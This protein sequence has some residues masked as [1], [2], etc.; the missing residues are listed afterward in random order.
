MHFFTIL[1][2]FKSKFV[3]LRLISELV[4]L[5]HGF[6][7]LLLKNVLEN[8]NR[9]TMN[10]K[11]TSKPG[12]KR[13]GWIVLHIKCLSVYF[14]SLSRVF[15]LASSQIFHLMMLCFMNSSSIASKTLA[16]S[17][18][19]MLIV[20]EWKHWQ[21][22][23]NPQTW[24][25]ENGKE[26]PIES[27]NENRKRCEILLSADVENKPNDFKAKYHLLSHWLTL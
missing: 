7:Q 19:S 14:I 15:G 13:R 23:M 6:E 2:Y 22:A 5:V 17:I 26:T 1:K 25:K 24:R 3:V 11:M 12:R 27:E 9:E 21:R 10:G 4:V 16:E 8:M 20:W 18:Q